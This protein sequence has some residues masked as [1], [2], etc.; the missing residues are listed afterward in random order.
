MFV[1]AAFTATVKAQQ[2]PLLSQYM[3]NGFLVNPAV[4]GAD[5]YTSITLTAREQWLGIAD[6][7]RTHIL[8]F[9][10]RL[11]KNNFVSRNKSVWRK[12]MSKKRS[13]RVGIG[14]Y[15]YNDKNGLIDR[16]GA[17]FTYAYHIKMYQSQL[18]FGLSANF[19]Q[20]SI[21]RNRLSLENDADALINKSD[22]VMFIPDFNFG[23]YF[24]CPKYY[25]GLSV[26]QL[27]NSV[28]QLSNNNSSQFRSYRQLSLTGGFN[29][30]LENDIVIAPSIYLKIT[31]QMITQVD[32]STKVY[33]GD[34]YYGGISFR[35]GSAF[36]L[37][38]GVTVDK[39]TFGYSFD[40]NFNSIQQHSLG[41]HEVMAAIKFGNGARRY[42][43]INR[44]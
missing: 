41:S 22:L 23:A 1:I 6:A 7:P 32:I 37:M 27:S 20:Y 28:I 44:Y 42:R 9:Q 5:G 33:F 2:L 36:I 12:F 29:F 18:S 38:G 39:Y 25:A 35:T 26:S 40:Y 4:A 11:L 17:Q 10:G 19:Y 34:M 24:S 16:T 3:F 15:V 43:W 8:A 13:G 31:N 14:G 30:D 21:N